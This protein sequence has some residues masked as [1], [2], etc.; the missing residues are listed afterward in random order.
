VTQVVIDEEH[1]YP[2]ELVSVGSVYLKPRHG[3]FVFRKEFG[4]A[5]C[6]DVYV[7]NT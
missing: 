3:E 1:Y 7:I 4:F 2:A 5:N 6:G